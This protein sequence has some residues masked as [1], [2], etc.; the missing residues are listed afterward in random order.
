MFVFGVGVC[1]C[2]LD[3]GNPEEVCVCMNPCVCLVSLWVFLWGRKEGGTVYILKNEIKGGK[4]YLWSFRSYPFPIGQASHTLGQ[5]P[6]A[7]KLYNSAH[8]W[9]FRKL[10][11]IPG[12]VAFPLSKWR[13]NLV[14]VL[15]TSERLDHVGQSFISGQWQGP[16]VGSNL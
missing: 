16:E 9:P 14:W 4:I 7:S 10:D 6:Q 1:V 15:L 11:P 5:F 2:V 3:L 12:T 13:G 8:W